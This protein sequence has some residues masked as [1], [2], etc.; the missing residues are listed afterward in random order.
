MNRFAL[1]AAGLMAASAQ[2]ELAT[3]EMTFDYYTYYEGGLQLANSAGSIIASW[4]LSYGSAG[5]FWTG[6]GASLIVSQSTLVNGASSFAS[7]LTN[8]VTL[9]L[10]QG[11]YTITL[12]DSYGDGWIT[13]DVV[14]GVNGY[15]DNAVGEG[16]LMDGGNAVSGT[17]NVVPAPASLA[18]LGLAGLSRRR[19]D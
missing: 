2:A 4:T 18:L 19:R 7:G 13:G 9:D 17:F 15:Y 11:E 6:S 12:T 8:T 10:A 5:S 14:G 16:F 1:S 3:I